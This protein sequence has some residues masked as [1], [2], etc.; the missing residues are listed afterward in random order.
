MRHIFQN[1]FH[2]GTVGVNG[3]RLLANVEPYSLQ[4]MIAQQNR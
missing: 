4:L 2:D 1:I 3:S